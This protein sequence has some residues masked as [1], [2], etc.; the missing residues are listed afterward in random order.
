MKNFVFFADTTSSNKEILKIFPAV[1]TPLHLFDIYDENVFEGR[2]RFKKVFVLNE[3]HVHRLNFPMTSLVITVTTYEN[4]ASILLRIKDSIWWNHEAQFLLVNTAS[5]GCQ[6]AYDVLRI[7][8]SY[9]VLSA[10]Y[11]CI[12]FSSAVSIYTYNP[13]SMRAPKSWNQV[14]VE[15]LSSGWTMFEFT[16]EQ[17]LLEMVLNSRMYE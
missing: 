10:I 3:T 16:E 11:L 7:L 15:T 8:W 12:K 13:Y 2:D 4:L 5:E 9:N 14:P 6:K 17:M 1:S